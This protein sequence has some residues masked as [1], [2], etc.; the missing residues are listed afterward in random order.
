[1]RPPKQPPSILRTIA[2][3]QEEEYSE[4]KPFQKKYG[5]QPMKTSQDVLSVQ[6]QSLG[7][8]H[9]T[10]KTVGRGEG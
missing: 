1:M 5:Q 10:K 6:R 4:S 8:T 7:E 9:T 2:H 3:R